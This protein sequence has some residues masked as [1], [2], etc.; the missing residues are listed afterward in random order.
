MDLLRLFCELAGVKPRSARKIDGMNILPIL[1]GEVSAS[2]HEILYYYNGTNLQAI[3]E[4]N[5]KLHLP[6]T[7]KDQPFWTK[8]AS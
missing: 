5:W 4:V 1:K 3:R 6:R 8:K 2:P 7:T